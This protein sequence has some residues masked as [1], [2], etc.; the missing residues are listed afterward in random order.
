M[1]VVTNCCLFA[2][3][4]YCLV[5]VL[6]IFCILSR[7]G[8]TLHLIQ[9]MGTKQ[10]VLFLVIKCSLLSIFSKLKDVM[11]VQNAISRLEKLIHTA[12]FV[13]QV[14]INQHGVSIIIQETS[15]SAGSILFKYQ[16]LKKIASVLAFS[17]FS[18]AFL[19][20]GTRPTPEW[21]FIV[22]HY[23]IILSI[24]SHLHHPNP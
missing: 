6:A 1:S 17:S 22:L 24:I 10:F 23:D 13:L 18:S 15:Y 14:Q 5:F 16:S 12:L 11:T 2:R 7:N 3:E 4:F 20:Q 8:R 9:G 19:S 21:E